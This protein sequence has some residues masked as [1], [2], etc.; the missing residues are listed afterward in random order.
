MTEEV[1]NKD[2]KTLVNSWNEWDPLKH[3][4]VGVA[5]GCFIPPSEPA[6]ECK[7]P[8]D[9]DMKGKWGPRPQETVEKANIQLDNFADIML[10]RGIRVDRPTPMDFSQPVETPDFEQLSMFGCM[11]PRDVIVTVGNEMLEATMSYRSRWFEYLCYRPLIEQYYKEDPNMRWEAA[12]KP[13]LT[14]ESYKPGYLQ[15]VMTIEER[16]KLTA[17][18]DFITTEKEPLFDAAEFARFGKD[19][20]IQHGFTANLSGI[21]WVQRHFPDLRIHGMNFPGDPYPIHIDCTFIPLRPGLVL[22]NP[23]RNVLPEPRQFFE[24]NNWEIVEAAQPAH[25]KPPP[26]CYSSVWLSMNVLMLDPN[27]VCVEASEIATMEQL[28][29]LGFEV[30]PVPFRDAYPFGGGL[31]CA[32]TDVYREG[33]C[34]DYFPKQLAGF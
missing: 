33:T 2:Q 24:I 12:P 23:I 11:P 26:L 8:I 13:R 32:T 3:V 4:I 7:I 9:S 22:N 34:E 18:K 27:T 5:D 16:L 17:A 10:K 29:K 19:I 25:E 6:S 1:K 14:D 30:V 15:R 28:D 21:D 20:V 31:H